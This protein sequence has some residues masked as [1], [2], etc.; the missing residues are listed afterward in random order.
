MCEE[1]NDYNLQVCAIKKDGV[2]QIE[3]KN[4]NFFRIN[5]ITVEIVQNEVRKMEYI[6]S[7]PAEGC[8]KPGKEYGR[9]QDFVP[10]GYYEGHEAK[11]S[12][13]KFDA[14][15]GIYR[16]KEHHCL[17]WQE[18][19]D[20]KRRHVLKYEFPEYSCVVMLSFVALGPRIAFIGHSFTGLWDSAYYYF[21]ELAAMDGYQVQLAYSYWGG[22][23][24]ARYAGLVEGFENRKEQC[25]RVLE[26]NDYYDFCVFCGN[27]DEAVMLSQRERMLKGA[28]ILFEKVKQ[29]NARMILWI[30]Q[31]YK[32]GFFDNMNVKPWREGSIG[33]QYERDGKKYVLTMTRKNMTEANMFWYGFIQRSIGAEDC[34]IAPVG[35]VYEY[36]AENVAERIDPYLKAG[37]ECGDYGHQNNLGNYIAACVLYALILRKSPEGLLVPPSHSWGMAGGKITLKQA[38]IIQKAAWKITAAFIKSEI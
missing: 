10:V 30:P 16:S 29:K 23:G 33:E 18:K 9:C 5:D 8:W 13:N 19:A 1:N 35:L 38:E 28:Q 3:V 21:R 26:A 20:R 37:V 32:Y 15:S 7:I 11:I 22:T 2:F 6:D 24:I 25:D 4:K 17:V 12:E 27:S 34:L 14:K 31:A 36:L